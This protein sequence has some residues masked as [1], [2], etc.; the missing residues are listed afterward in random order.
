MEK[1]R[2]LVVEDELKILQ[3][4]R[5]YL[6]KEG[7][8]VS[9]ATDGE[10]ALSIFRSFQPDLIVLDR[11]LPKISGDLLCTRFRQESDIPIIILSARSTE[12]DRVFGLQIGADDYLTK[13]FSPREL[14]ARIQALLRRCQRREDSENRVIRLD[15]GRFII[16]PVRFELRRD[17]RLVS[18]TPTEFNLL[19]VLASHPGQVFR[20]AQLV[21]ATMG[22]N[23]V[24]GYDRTI[25][26]HIKN[27]RQK[28]EADPS[29]PKYIQTV[30]GV[31]YRFAGECVSS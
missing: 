21:E 5:A 27:I 20:R 7:Y 11:M 10:A 25:D 24:S 23:A 6:E 1:E 4:I 17:G 13:P 15:Q 31:G 22:S 2:I 16:D 28:I 26:A 3:I 12:D 30:F 8:E 9:S 18:L 19:T 14:V 29:R